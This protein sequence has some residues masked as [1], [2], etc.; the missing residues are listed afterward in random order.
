MNAKLPFANQA[1]RATEPLP[2]PVLI[3]GAGGFIG[4]HL[5]DACVVRG[6]KVRAFVRYNSNSRWGWLDDS[7]LRKEM[8]I[9]PG[10]VRDYDSVSRAMQ[11]CGTVLHL[12]ALIGIPHSYL[13]PLAYVRTN[14][15]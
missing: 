9:I 4:S 7:P 2:S 1:L 13:S 11:G 15:E 5:A 6:W 12:A 14:I 3:T 8:E 10:D